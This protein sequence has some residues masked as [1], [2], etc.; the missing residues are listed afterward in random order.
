MF[1]LFK[2]KCPLDLEEWQW[3]LAGLKWLESEFPR[4]NNSIAAGQLVLPLEE[5]FPEY[6]A[7][8]E[9][10]Q[11]AFDRVK[12]LARLADWPTILLMQ[13]DDQSRHIVN[14]AFAGEYKWTDALGTFS[15]VHDEQSK[16]IAQITYHPRQL[17]NP[18]AFVA[19]MAHE[20]GH[21]LMST[22]TTCPPGGWD[23][24]ELATDLTAV[25][26]G[27]GI[28][29]ANSAKSFEG[30]SD[31]DRAGWQSQ[32]SGYLNENTLLAA[33]AVCET[34]QGNDPLKARPYL[35]PYLQSDLKRI[36]KYIQSADIRAELEQIDLADY[37]IEKVSAASLN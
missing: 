33:M 11:A 22:S 9:Y 18:E 7:S 37:G 28:F 29:M 17:L 4:S 15:I 6:S 30:F 16:P 19:T 35:K 8:A 27:F 21:Y 5:N 20:L 24:H 25:W 12:E 23:L 31:H 34:L 14:A 36:A 1:S 26:M 13:E 32:M 2:P 10:A 3:M